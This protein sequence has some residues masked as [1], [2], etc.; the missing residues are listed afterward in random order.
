MS[1]NQSTTTSAARRKAADKHCNGAKCNG[2]KITANNYA[3][4]KKAA[5]HGDEV[6]FQLCR[7]TECGLCHDHQCK[8]LSQKFVTHLCTWFCHHAPG[9]ATMHLVLP[10]CTWFCHHLHLVLPP[11]TWFCHHL[12]LVLPPSAPG[13]ATICT[14]FCHQVTNFLR[15]KINILILYYRAS[16]ECQRTWQAYK[17][18]VWSMLCH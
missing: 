8:F 13:F 11:C 15:Q 17:H 1:D 2:K 16:A 12:H 5:K 3:E 7:G 18:I 9:F 14:W 4:H 6:G 10:P